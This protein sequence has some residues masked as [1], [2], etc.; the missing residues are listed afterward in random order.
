MSTQS[1]VPT[2]KKPAMYFIKGFLLTCLFG[3]VVGAIFMA[4]FNKPV[5]QCQSKDHDQCILQAIDMERKDRDAF[6][7]AREQEIA[8]FVSQKNAEI[9]EYVTAKDATIEGYKDQ[10]KPETIEAEYKANRLQNV[11]SRLLKLMVPEAKADNSEVSLSTDESKEPTVAPL[12]VVPNR[13]T[14]V[15][16]R[17]NA[18]YKDV[19]IE[20]YC[21]DAGMAQ[22][23]C[24][25]M[26]AIAQQESQ[27]GKDYHCVQQ[28]KAYA[29]T[30]GQTY[31]HNPMGLTDA[32]VHYKNYARTGKKNADFQGCFIRKFDSWEDFWS[33]MPKSF[34]DTTKPYYV[35]NWSTVK[36]LSGIWVNGD[37]SRPSQNWIN[38]VTGVLNSGTLTTQ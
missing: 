23:D 5:T 20:K 33:F 31:Y 10:L 2:T 22:R 15:L 6:K 1:T 16:A 25:I 18:P 13:Y 38:T 35:G 11:P 17:Y 32:T 29:I 9:T 28:T 12:P 30:L 4:M 21:K 36:E 24:D 8:N 19:N 37:I 34:M 27:M 14:A 26:V 3:V 7:E